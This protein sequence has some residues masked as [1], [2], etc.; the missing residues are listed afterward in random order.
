MLV[1]RPIICQTKHLC[2]SFLPHPFFFF[3]NF[4]SSTMGTNSLKVAMELFFLFFLFLIFP[5]TSSEMHLPCRV[6]GRSLRGGGR[7]SDSSR[8]P[9]V[10]GGSSICVGRVPRGGDLEEDAEGTTPLDWMGR[11]MNRWSE[12]WIQCAAPSCSQSLSRGSF[13]QIWS[14]RFMTS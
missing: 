1:R 14:E 3:Y 9:G 13:P 10:G 4:S 12:Y 8:E 2:V 6:S 11:W 5:E 7:S